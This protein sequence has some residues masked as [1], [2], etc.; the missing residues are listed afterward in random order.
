[1]R[2]LSST[3]RPEAVSCR[4]QIWRAASVA[5]SKASSGSGRVRERKANDWLS[6]SVRRRSASM[7][8]HTAATSEMI[9]PISAA[10]SRMA[11]LRSCALAWRSVSSRFCWASARACA[12]CSSCWRSASRAAILCCNRVAAASPCSAISLLLANSSASA[13]RTPTSRYSRDWLAACHSPSA[14]SKRARWRSALR[15]SLIALRRRSQFTI[16]RS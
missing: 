10:P 15:R 12:C 6:A 8:S 3:C 16:S 1:M 2:R 7:P 4:S 11:R 9:A 5:I 13:R 14:C